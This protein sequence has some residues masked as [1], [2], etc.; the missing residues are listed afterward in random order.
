MRSPSSVTMK[1]HDAFTWSRNCF[2][3]QRRHYYFQSNFL[4]IFLNQAKDFWVC[5]CW[6]SQLLPKCHTEYHASVRNTR[7][8]DF[9][10]RPEFPNPIILS[11]T[12][13][14]QNPSDSNHASVF[15]QSKIFCKRQKKNSVA[16]ARER[17]IP[18]ER[19]PL[20]GEVSAN[21]MRI[22]GIGWS[23]QGISMAVFSGY[24]SKFVDS[25]YGAMELNLHS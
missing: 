14:R 22:E 21:S 13:H 20:V 7:L 17:T 1:N 4:A 12:N 15:I 18:T 25:S 24:L 3:L 10:R 11:V 23:T 16:L 9:V 19:L 6:H 2:A 5:K 8:L